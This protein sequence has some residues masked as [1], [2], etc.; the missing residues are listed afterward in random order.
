MLNQEAFINRLNE[1]FEYYNLTA[2]SFAD[3]I[4]VQR[5]SISH[6]L[7]G[8]NKPS[9]DFVLK[10]IDTYK[11]LTL[12]WLLY[13]KGSFP[14]EKEFATQ[15]NIATNKTKSSQPDLFSEKDTTTSEKTN[16]DEM[17]VTQKK[18]TTP[19]DIERIV[20][21]YTNGTFKEYK[22]V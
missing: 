12:D 19:S 8:R 10:M 14:K 20:I 22:N 7:S 9:L 11:E 2:A 1:V 18:I 15:P 16:E 5:S 21:F 3:E 4:K 17:I 13:G 6:L